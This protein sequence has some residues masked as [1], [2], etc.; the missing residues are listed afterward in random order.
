M[1]QFF[2]HIVLL[3]V[4]ALGWKVCL[5]YMIFYFF[6]L[7]PI[8]RS[9]VVLSSWLISS[10]TVK[11]NFFGDIGSSSTTMLLFFCPQVATKIR[12]RL[13]IKRLF[14]FFGPVFVSMSSDKIFNFYHQHN[15]DNIMVY[16]VKGIY[17]T[18]FVHGKPKMHELQ[19]DLMK[20]P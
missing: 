1:C 6:P 13:G 7:T 11:L 12:L 8:H 14:H 18:N 2:S 4:F 3:T 16:L 5:W 19:K 15:V 9:S 17:L 20:I 10:L